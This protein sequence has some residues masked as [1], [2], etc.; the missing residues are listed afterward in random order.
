VSA[1]TNDRTSELAVCAAALVS[2]P[3][4]DLAASI[5]TSGDFYDP[6][7]GHVF[8]VV[9]QLRWDKKP[10][11]SAA[12]M[13]ALRASGRTP[14][15]VIELTDAFFSAE[16]SSV[17]YHAELVRSY[18][19]RRR[20]VME[21]RTILQKAENPDTSTPSLAAEAVQALAR[22]R[23]DGASTE[24]TLRRLDAVMAVEEPD[25]D[26]VVPSLLERGDRF[27]LTGS[28][29]LGKS[30]LLRQMAVCIAAGINPFTHV[31]DFEPANVVMVDTENTEK[32][33]RRKTRGVV[34][35]ARAMGE[36]PMV[37]MWLEHPG[38]MDITQ[39]R[40]LSGLHRKLD[41]ARADVL[42]IG[43]LYKLVPR[44]IQTDD[45]AAPVLVA[46]DSVRDRGVTLILEAH[47]GH[48]LGPGGERNW[49]PRGS[50]ALM[51]WPEFGYGVSPM[52][53]TRPGE[54]IQARMQPWRGDRD[55]RDWP[56]LLKRG[57]KFPWTE[58]KVSG[59]DEPWSP[60]DALGG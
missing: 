44:A 49:R 21:C 17:R 58:I 8:E 53:D 57:G 23:D 15:V 38:R 34:A 20:L 18:A 52:M 55:E 40:D 28:E 36:D 37:R 6:Q 35:Q 59:S 47:A 2:G 14:D 22:V 4:V 31:P 60:H 7:L 30:V 11:D 51:G 5:L 3:A 33:F 42:V 48:G 26:W 25:Y 13:S 16:S 19:T 1:V 45:E 46:L 27:V 50:A 43:P 56:R 39:D 24:S 10:H 41:Q 54:P 29:G 32:Q 12:V 9:E